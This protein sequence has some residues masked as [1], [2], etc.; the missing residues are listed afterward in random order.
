M[1]YF[2]DIEKEMRGPE[3]R[4]ASKTKRFVNGLIDVI[5][6]YVM[7]D[8]CA[9][10]IIADQNYVEL[11]SSTIYLNLMFIFFYLFYYTFLE[12]ATN[13]TLGKL[14]TKTHVVQEDGKR[15]NFKIAVIRSLC[16]LIP[17][18]ALSFLGNK[19]TDWHDTMSKTRVVNDNE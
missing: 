2:S 11:R 9:L 12:L 6:I 14:I 3:S 19:S 8:I 4:K 18:G 16:R 17:F 10:F 13:K 5:T 7:T 15:L 1:N